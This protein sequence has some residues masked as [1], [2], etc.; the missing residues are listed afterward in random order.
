MQI[1]RWLSLSGSRKSSVKELW[2][3]RATVGIATPAW[4]AWQSWCTCTK[5]ALKACKNHTE[6]DPTLWYRFSKHPRITWLGLFIRWDKWTLI[7]LAFYSCVQHKAI[8]TTP[9]CMWKTARI[10]SCD[11]FFCSCVFLASDRKHTD[12]CLPVTV[13]AECMNLQ[14]FTSGVFL[15]LIVPVKV[16][17]PSF[18]KICLNT[19]VLPKAVP[20]I[21]MM[22]IHV[23]HNTCL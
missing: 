11:L 8:E 13:F 22:P 5:Q 20:C 10:P 7:P 9:D 6:T 2:E 17:F 14:N 12:L 4:D 19:E 21:I 15:F 1:I 18:C 3:E 16:R 23:D